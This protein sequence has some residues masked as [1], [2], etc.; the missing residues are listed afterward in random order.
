MFDELRRNTKAFIWIM[1]IAFVG[2]IFLAWGADFQ[3]S[4]G[5]GQSARAG[6]AGRVNGEPISFTQWSGLINYTMQSMQQQGQTVDER[7]ASVIR[8]QAWNNLVQETLLRQEAKKRGLGVTDRE[9]A[10]AVLNQP[11]QEFRQHPNFQTNGQF[12]LAKYQ[13][14]LRSPSFDTRPIEMQYR[15]SL[16][17][18]KLQNEVMATVVVPEQELWSAFRIRNETVKVSYLRIPAGNF[19]N[20][21]NDTELSAEQV[22]AYYRDH[23]KEYEVA[24]EAIVEYVSFPKR[25]SSEDSLNA[26]DLA[27]GV[28]EDVAAGEDFVQQVVDYSE[29][30]ANQ[31]GGETAT[32]IPISQVPVSIRAAVTSLPVGQVSDLI[33]ARDGFHVVRVEER[34]ETEGAPGPDVRLA[35]LFLPLR[36]SQETMNTVF[37]E[38]RTFR[39]EVG[40]GDLQKVAGDF[41]LTIRETPPFTETG[42]IQGLGPAPEVQQ[43]AFANP[44]GTVSGPLDRADDWIIVQIK[45]RRDRRTPALAEVEKRVRSEAANAQRVELAKAAAERLLPRFQ[46][47]ESL[48]SIASGDSLLMQDTTDAFSRTTASRGIGND[49]DL[50][51]PIFASPVGRMNHVLVGRGGAYLVEILEK[52][53]PDRAS[54]DAQKAQLREEAR[55]N[56]QNQLFMAWLDNL[57]DEA[58][59]KDFRSG[60]N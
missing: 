22:E 30:P 13:A 48:E 32:W 42:F 44:V 52:N 26:A 55:Q 33:V 15:A 25:H 46:G 4:A 6:E 3:M 19:Q 1:V 41:G 28:I 45:E 58:T 10:D 27:R 37:T 57:T 36:A 59:I 23:A 17:L 49:P 2:L 12:D 5:G 21:I 43:F 9:V 11:L 29:A 16:P 7:T 18:E 31:R 60:V 54:F 53:A 38:A 50:V 35:H 34:R 47:G 8:N 20:Q 40:G 51:G 56:R 24:P 14:T 39:Q